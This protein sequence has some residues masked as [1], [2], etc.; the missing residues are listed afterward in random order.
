MGASL[1]KCGSRTDGHELIYAVRDGNHDYLK[2]LTNRGASVN[3]HDC[4]G[5]TALFKAA[6]HGVECAWIP[7]LKQELM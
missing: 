6:N 7:L 3:I 5:E 1:C 4:D 2:T